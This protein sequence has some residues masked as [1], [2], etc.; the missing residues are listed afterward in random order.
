MKKTASA[1]L[2]PILLVSCTEQ[3]PNYC[4]DGCANA[5]SP[6][7]YSVQDTDEGNEPPPDL[8]SHAD[9]GELGSSLDAQTTNDLA[10]PNKDLSSPIDLTPPKDL[11]DL[12][13]RNK[14]TDDKGLVFQAGG[15]K[16]ENGTLQNTSYDTSIAY[17]GGI[18]FKDFDLKIRGRVNNERGGGHLFVPF[19]YTTQGQFDQNKDTAYMMTLDSWDGTNFNFGLMR[20]FTD[21]LRTEKVSGTHSTFY[22]LEVKARGPNIDVIFQGKSFQVVNNLYSDG[23]FGFASSGALV[24][25]D[26]IEVCPK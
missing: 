23:Y 1:L 21:R 26:D 20:L 14:F 15:W 25:F 19:R 17:V 5:P 12:C 8:A 3:N 13:Y 11:T 2:I 4:G 24:E 9:Q 10:D 6:D 22:Q 16:V 18:K 7:L